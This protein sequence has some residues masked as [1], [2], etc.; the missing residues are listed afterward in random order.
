MLAT[1]S[2]LWA[3]GC[4]RAIPVHPSSAPAETAFG[5]PSPK[6]ELAP[7]RRLDHVVTLGLD[8]SLPGPRAAAPQ[9]DAPSAAPEA[10]LY[11]VPYAGYGG[12]GYGYG[13]GRYVYG[14]YGAALDRRYST[15]TRGVPVNPVTG[16]PPVAGDWRP[17]Q[18]YGPRAM[19]R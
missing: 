10:P 1:T 12:Y 3:L 11:V 6:P 14:S 15:G 8:T 13:S 17:P 4:A 16:T 5:E 18:S 19:G 2:V 9:R 7:R